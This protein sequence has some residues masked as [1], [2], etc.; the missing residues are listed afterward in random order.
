LPIKHFLMP[1]AHKNKILLGVGLALLAWFLAQ[2]DWRQ[3]AAALAG[4]QPGLLAAA[5]LGNFLTPVLRAARFNQCYRLRGRQWEVSALMGQFGLLN[6]VLP[7]RTGEVAF[8]ALLKTRGVIRQ[9]T[10]AVPRWIF[11]RICDLAG[12]LLLV[13][14][15]ALCIRALKQFGPWLTTAQIGL[16]LACVVLVA[17]IVIAPRLHSLDDGPPPRWLGRQL[18]MLRRGLAGLESRSGAAVSFAWTLAIWGWATGMLALQYAAFPIEL[19]V[20]ELWALSVGVMAMSVLPIHAPL[21]V[22]TMHAVQLALLYGLGIRGS[23]ALAVAV[24]N[25]A[26]MVVIVAGEAA[27]GTLYLALTGRETAGEVIDPLLTAPTARGEKVDCP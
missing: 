21:A 9:V 14:V 1:L 2:A 11:L 15:T 12:L 6:Q 7:A 18:W 3:M 8:L 17:M 16:V 20:G 24:G 22:G 10:E 13:V 4:V 19:T 26:A 23:E 27:V 5:I 25:H